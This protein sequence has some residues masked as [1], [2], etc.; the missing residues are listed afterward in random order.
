MTSATIEEKPFGII[1]TDQRGRL[2]IRSEKR[3]AILAALDQSTLSV[4]GFCRQHGLCYSTVDHWN[5][6]RRRAGAKPSLPAVKSQFVEVSVTSKPVV[7][8]SPLPVKVIL[9]TGAT[10]EISDSTQI[11]LL[12]ELLGIL[13]PARP[14]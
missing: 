1:R 11:P 3:Q 14:Y 5:Q 6:K 12:A 13:P 7:P 8:V 4:M 2:L 10:V 9:P